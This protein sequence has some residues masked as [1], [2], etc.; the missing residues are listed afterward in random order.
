MGE[1]Q[2]PPS[3]SPAYSG[4][5]KNLSE[6]RLA[7]EHGEIRAGTQTGLRLCRLPV[8]SQ[9]WPGLTDTGP[10]A[11]PSAENTG[12]NLLTSLFGPAVHVLNRSANSQRSKYTLVYCTG[13]I[14]WHLKSSWRVPESLEKVIPTPKSLHPHLK[15]WLEESNVLQ[16]QPLH[17]IRHAL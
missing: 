4:T 7:G 12:S 2:I 17:P 15:W 11:D 5:S 6:T 14:Q 13:P 10:V 9:M 16:G 3:L 1:S 8:G